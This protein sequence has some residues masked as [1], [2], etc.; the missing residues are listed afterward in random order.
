MRTTLLLLVALSALVVLPGLAAS[1]DPDPRR[2]CDGEPL[3]DLR[4]CYDG[5]TVHTC[6]SDD[7]L[8]GLGCIVS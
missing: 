2:L 8:H 7:Q 3:V 1:Q 6:K 5:H 4:A